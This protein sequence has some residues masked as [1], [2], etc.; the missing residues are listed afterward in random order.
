MKQLVTAV[1]VFV[2]LSGASATTSQEKSPGAGPIIVLETARGTIEF[3]TYPEEAP[4]T[5]ARI[6]ELVN[7]GFYNG[8]RFHRA[9]ANFLIQIG[10]PASRD[11]SREAD[12][13][14]GGTGK[15]I[16]ASEV[17][18]KR[19]HLLGA[20]SMAYPGTQRRA[21]DSQFFIMRRPAPELDGKYTVFGSVLKGQEVVGRIQKGDL[22]KRAYLKDE[23][24][25]S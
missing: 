6:V 4:K 19:R 3:E 5:V 2:G 17:T 23:A 22:L 24:A 21:A 12:W 1:L 18:K 10:D 25:R 11:V 9:E 14:G 7:K 16:G 15:P 8:L 20:V 13:G